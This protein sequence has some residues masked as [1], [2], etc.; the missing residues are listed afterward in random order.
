MRRLVITII[1]ISIGAIVSGATYINGVESA[2]SFDATTITAGTVTASTSVSTVN[3]AASGTADI[4]GKTSIGNQ[5][6]VSNATRSLNVCSSDAVV[7]ILRTGSSDAALELITRGTADGADTAFWDFFADA[8]T[9]D[10][11]IRDRDNGNAERIHIDTSGNIEIGYGE[12]GVDYTFTW[13]GET[14]DLVETYDEDNDILKN[15]GGYQADD[16]YSGD[17]TQGMTGTCADGTSLTV[18]DGIVTSCS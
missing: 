4:D 10:F 17:G 18:K 3:F 11:I 14:N 9:G 2:A 13:D 8:A 7:R 16:Y 15:D 12:A 1:A 6:T 5:V